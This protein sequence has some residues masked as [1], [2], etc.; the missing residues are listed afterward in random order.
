MV[1]MYKNVLSWTLL[2]LF[3][4][5]GLEKMGHCRISLQILDSET[6]TGSPT[7]ETAY[8]GQIEVGINKFRESIS[9]KP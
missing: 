9:L 7:P 2:G 6:D 4:L 5:F 3:L 8:H 1:M